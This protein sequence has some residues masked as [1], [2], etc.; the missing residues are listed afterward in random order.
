MLDTD[1]P[2]FDKCLKLLG[3]R[4]GRRIDDDL[5]MHYFEHLQKY[6]ASAVC[7]VLDYWT[8]HPNHTKLPTEADLIAA[9]K[10][11]G[12]RAES[13]DSVVNHERDA[14]IKKLEDEFTL[15]CKRVCANYPSGNFVTS[16]LMHRVVKKISIAVDLLSHDYSRYKSTLTNEELFDKQKDISNKIAFEKVG[17]LPPLR[18]D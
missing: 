10:L 9:I 14:N 11:K 13:G 8:H 17:V 4:I 12:A 16:P 18:S 3:K 2:R 5:V 6:D 7:F 15:S 1:L